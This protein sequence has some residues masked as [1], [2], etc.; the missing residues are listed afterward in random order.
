MLLGFQER[1][2][3]FVLDGSKTHTI[4]AERKVEM[5][6]GEMCHCYV[7][8]RRKDMK[9]LGRWPCVR[10]EYIEIYERGD[11]TFG[12]VISSD[13][14]NG[15]ARNW[16]ELGSCEKD[17]LAWK[18]GFRHARKATTRGCFKLMMDYWKPKNGRPLDFRGVIVHWR[19]E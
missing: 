6:A 4:R 9:L 11:G 16:H 2:A 14:R 7:N 18:D 3:P 10:V 17:L 5:K 8:P 1:F 12:V 19:F 13:Y 15:Y